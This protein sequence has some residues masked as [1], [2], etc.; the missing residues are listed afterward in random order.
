MNNFLISSTGTT[1]FTGGPGINGTLTLDVTGPFT[2]VPTISS[3]VGGFD[4]RA[5]SD[6][7]PCPS[8]VGHITV[9]VHPFPV[10][11][12]GNFQACAGIPKSGNLNPLVSG[13]PPFTFSGPLSQFNGVAT[14]S[15]GG[16][17]TFTPN[18]GVIT[19]NFSYGVTSA[20]G[21]PASGEY[22]FSES[23]SSCYGGTGISC[24][25]GQAT[26]SLA[27]LVSG[28]TPPYIFQLVPTSDR[29]ALQR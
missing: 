22:F 1:T 24:Q 13:D 26:G 10:T 6:V 28:G 2:F 8:P 17:F 18:V 4:F 3:G 7:L 9:N 23:N 25:N 15:P 5:F 21:C 16:A 14:V 27:P 29:V 11:K 20:F 12:T 19:G